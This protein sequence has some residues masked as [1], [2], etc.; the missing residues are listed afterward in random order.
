[1]SGSSF[2]EHFR[3][4]EFSKQSGHFLQIKAWENLGLPVSLAESGGH[5]AQF[6]GQR[7]HP[8]KFL[9]KHYPI[10]SQEHGER[11]V[12][13]DRK[14]RWNAKE[15]AAGWHSHY[16]PI[17]PGHVFLRPRS[18]LRIYDEEEFNKQYLVE[19]LSGV[20]VHRKKKR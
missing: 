14:M 1:V 8:Y 7:V 9:L 18:E 17:Q 5:N 6:K 2:E 4:F 3:H 11:K 20:G 10:R 12:F 13:Y 19:R 16:D 15:R